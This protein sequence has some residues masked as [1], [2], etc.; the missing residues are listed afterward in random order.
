MKSLSLILASA[1]ALWAWDGWLFVSPG[2]QNVKASF[3]L[4]N[5]TDPMSAGRDGD[6][7]VSALPIPNGESSSNSG[8]KMGYRELRV[9]TTGFLS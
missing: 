6:A 2:E 3:F 4:K 8:E 1:G 7:L 5:R 9:L